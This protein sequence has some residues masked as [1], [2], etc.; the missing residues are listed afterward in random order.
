MSFRTLSPPDNVV[1]SATTPAIF[2]WLTAGPELDD[3]TIT[4]NGQLIADIVNFTVTN[5]SNAYTVTVIDQ[6]G[7]PDPYL[8]IVT[9]VSG[10]QQSPSFVEID[11]NLG[12][13]FSQNRT[14]TVGEGYTPDH[15]DTALD[16][17]LE[18][19]QG[20]VNLRALA[21]SYVDQAQVLEN[22]TIQL[23]HDRSINTA[24]GHRLDGL[25][26][27]AN[28]P[29][30]GLGD[31]DY[32]LRIRVELAVLTSQ[33][34]IEDLIVVLSLLIDLGTPP[35]VEIVE[36]FPKTI[37]MRPVDFA[38]TDDPNIIGVLL[39]RAVSA[40]TRLWFVYSEN[41]DDETYQLSSLPTTVETSSL[42]GLSNDAQ[43][44]GGYLA[45]VV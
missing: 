13:S 34:S 21:S 43:S 3:A 7:D 26:Q 22:A 24:T 28:I 18:Q 31:E 5:H 40:A 23:L 39:K 36:Y 2:R 14:L 41:L 37:A 17:M 6:G 45:N 10:W 29:R 27:L 19:F 8:Y 1:F 4:I 38:L 9:P 35:D 32:R 25:G 42:L 20:S 44:S 11:G 15:T 16:R 30:G 12:G 33:G